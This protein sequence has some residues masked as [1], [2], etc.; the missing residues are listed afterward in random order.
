MERREAV[1]FGLVGPGD[2]DVVWSLFVAGELAN[3][4]QITRL[5]VLRGDV[6]EAEVDIPYGGSLPSS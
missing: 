1:D 4:C 5:A 2:F 3:V 6:R